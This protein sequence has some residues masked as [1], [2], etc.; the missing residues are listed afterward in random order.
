MSLSKPLKL[1]V[2]PTERHNSSVYPAMFAVDEP[3]RLTQT[4]DCMFELVFIIASDE[5]VGIERRK[6]EKD[7]VVD[8]EKVSPTGITLSRWSP[9]MWASYMTYDRTCLAIS[10]AIR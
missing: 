9:K 8:M 6:M 7:W 10:L 3:H 1:C 2:P 4:L 5:K